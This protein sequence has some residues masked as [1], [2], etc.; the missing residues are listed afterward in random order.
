MHTFA[1]HEPKL[2]LQTGNILQSA[3]LTKEKN[4]LSGELRG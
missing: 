3:A 4:E 1:K 2:Q